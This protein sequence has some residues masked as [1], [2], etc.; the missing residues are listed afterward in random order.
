MGNI[1]PHDLKEYKKYFPLPHAKKA[2]TD[3]SNNS[4][5]EFIYITDEYLEKECTYFYSLISSYINKT[6]LEGKKK[7]TVNVN[8]FTDHTIEHI[9][10]YCNSRGYAAE[11]IKNNNKITLLVISWNYFGRNFEKGECP[12]CFD[13]TTLFDR[14]ECGHYVH[15][16]CYDEWSKCPICKN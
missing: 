16:K 4:E 13:N 7:F 5:N 6:I 15:D 9:A 3:S 14:Q 2:F 8:K 12:I 10:N 1:H 11:C